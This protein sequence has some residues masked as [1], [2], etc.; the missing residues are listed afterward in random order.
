M[1]LW[2]DNIGGGIFIPETYWNRL[3]HEEQQLFLE[4]WRTKILAQKE[5]K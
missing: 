1:I 4:L 2:D 3:S 5:K